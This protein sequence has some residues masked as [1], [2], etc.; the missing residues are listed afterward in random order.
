M[1]AERLLHF[2]PAQVSVGS[3]LASFLAIYRLAECDRLL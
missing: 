3:R 1:I 2:R